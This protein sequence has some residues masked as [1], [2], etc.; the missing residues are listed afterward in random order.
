M[1]QAAWWWTLWAVIGATVGVTV[2]RRWRR[3]AREGALH[4]VGV[5]HVNLNCSD[6]ERSRAFF[7]ML[8]FR[9]VMN[10]EETP[11]PSVAEAVAMPPYRIKGALLAHRDGMMLDLIEWQDPRDTDAPY[12]RLNHLG[13]A[14]LALV[15][16]DL[17]ADV[18]RLKAAGVTFL[19]DTPGAVADA[20]G[21]TTRF[22]CFFD[23]D[24]T[25]IELVELG[26]AMR[27]ARGASSWL[28]RIV[29]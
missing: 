15:T 10:V 13:L 21:G 28:K 2:L 24:G 3:A 5:L 12:R 22:I 9:H 26:H 6:F 11:S 1:S 29:R 25:V 16:S 20:L 19:S 4:V 17:D 27:M 7:E 14:R 8:G 23:P 18:A